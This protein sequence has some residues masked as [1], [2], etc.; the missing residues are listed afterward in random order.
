MLH[1]TTTRV[2]VPGAVAASL[3]VLALV[4]A[5]AHAADGA[6]AHA[7]TVVGIIGAQPATAATVPAPPAAATRG[8]PANASVYTADYS[9]RPSVAELAALG[10][11]LFF[12]PRLSASGR[13][14]CASCHDPAHAYGPPNGLA[15]QRSGADMQQQGTRAAPSLRYLQSVPP[16]TEHYF[17]ADDNDSE[18]QGP[19]GGLTWDGRGASA[20]D[21]AR[22]PLFATNEMA[23][24]SA[25]DLSARLRPTSSGA[26]LR[27]AFGNDVFDKDERVLAAVLWALE[28]FQQDPHEF[29]PYTSKYDAVLRGQA[30]LTAQEERGHQLFDAPD[31]GNCAVCHPSTTK[32]GALP[33][34]TDYGFIAVAAPRN[35]EA[36]PGGDTK[37]HDLGLCGPERLDL[38]QHSEYCG[39][40]RTPTL[41]NVALRKVFFH[42]GS[43][44]SLT[45]AVSFYATRDSDPQRWYGRTRDG[46]VVPYDDLPL[47][48]QDNINRD[49]PFGAKPG[50][51][52]ALTPAEVRDIVAF[53]G[54]LTDG[55]QPH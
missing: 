38:R 2:L 24:R 48:Y 15:V 26:A 49:P 29:Y 32:R 43:L 33:Q 55:W 19:V 30:T 21:Q 44:H 28:V 52:A 39:L 11:A 34:F 53:L 46:K 12:E 37:W 47:Q 16:F 41:R 8:A 17:E 45:D 25:A 10:R 9:R 5:L 13:T 4:H 42:N 1:P 18:D 3:A 7:T 23:N 27:A 14:A 6:D 50:Q 40:F 22:L 54:T 51:P 35:R 36:V 31:K 20:H